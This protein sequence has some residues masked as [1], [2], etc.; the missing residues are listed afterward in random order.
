[1]KT[2][3]TAMM[4]KSVEAQA[5]ILECFTAGVAPLTASV[6][7][8]FKRHKKQ[9]HGGASAREVARKGRWSPSRP[10]PSPAC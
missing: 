10:P 1:M 4:I 7:T 5:S 8:A 3:T 2:M 9:A 6:F